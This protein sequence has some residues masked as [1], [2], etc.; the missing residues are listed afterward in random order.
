MSHN[1]WAGQLPSRRQIC[2]TQ[3]HP[4]GS[5]T[6]FKVL[7][8][9]AAEVRILV[10]MHSGTTKIVDIESWS[11]FEG[12]MRAL[13]A[14]RESREAENKRPMNDPLFRGL[15]NSKWGLETTLERSFPM[16]RSDTTL[17]LVA[18]YRKMT[19]ALPA[20][21]TLT[22]Q[23]WSDIPGFAEFKKLLKEHNRDWLDG[24]LR[25][26][27]GIYRFMIYLRHHGFPSPLL[28][29]TAS[30]YVAA[31]FA[32]DMMDPGAEYVSVYAFLQD[33]LHS[34]GSDQHFFVVG[35]YI[36]AHR[37][38]FLQQ[39]RYSMCVGVD[40]DD[41]AFRAHESGMIG[42]D[43]SNG[44]LFKFRIRASERTTALKSLDLMNINAYSVFASEESLI[45]SVARREC[46]FRPWTF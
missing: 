17:S 32:F 31:L 3:D 43:G 11:D 8:R 26:H 37:R 9:E 30:P 33:T 20:V 27:V 45:R 4:S 5:R 23:R 29:W 21:E 22:E 25:K 7:K 18:Y 39:S 15:G 41:Y 44:N 14:H 1:A 42:P 13:A 2:P 12:Q 46:L 19:A 36:Q 35:P 38:H 28:D 40:S 34:F 16:D 6:A 10:V 24:F